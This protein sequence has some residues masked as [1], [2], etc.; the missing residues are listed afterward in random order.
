M[1]TANSVVERI[2]LWGSCSKI[3]K[4]NNKLVNTSTEL[5]NTLKDKGLTDNFSI[6]SWNADLDLHYNDP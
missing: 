1:L 5:F 6:K 2:Q 4:L 3:T